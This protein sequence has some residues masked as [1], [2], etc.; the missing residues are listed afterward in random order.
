MSEN[1]NEELDVELDSTPVKIRTP[2]WK[3]LDLEPA[4]AG[5]SLL[6]DEFGFPK[7]NKG[8][9]KELVPLMEELSSEPINIKA[10]NQSKDDD[11]F[12]PPKSNFVSVGQKENTWYSKEVTGVAALDENIIDN[13]EF[14]DTDSLQGLDPLGQ[15]MNKEDNSVVKYIQKNIL[16][17][18]Q[19]IIN[20]LNKINNL[21]ELNELSQKVFGKE[22]WFSNVTVKIKQENLTK[23]TALLDVFNLSIEKLFIEFEAKKYEFLTPEDDEYSQVELL[24]E[25]TKQTEPEQDIEE[26]MLYENQK[27]HSIVSSKK[28]IIELI[29]DL[30]TNCNVELSSLV[31]LKK[32]PIDFGIILKE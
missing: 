29:Y 6:H 28:E 12:I 9:E 10:N 23:N 32:I 13:T 26:Y 18:E 17:T 31:L 20:K 4:Q 11:K 2:E 27:L 14:V 5:K 19:I 22:G 8:K 1:N 3:R 24:E 7:V 15:I 16:E 30:I 21:E 25:Q